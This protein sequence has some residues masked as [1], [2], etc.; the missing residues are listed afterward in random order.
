MS[1]LEPPDRST[2]ETD[3][4]ETRVGETSSSNG[5]SSGSSGT[6]VGESGVAIELSAD[7]TQDEAAAV[8]AAIGAHLTNREQAA[9]V[10][11]AKSDSTTYVDEWRFASKLRSLGKRR[12]TGDVEAGDEWKA[13]G[14][15]FPR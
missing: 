3:A 1:Q 6:A 14:R 9:A 11:V 15:A 12:W 7:A 4:E 2:D 13:A 10:A 8:A 5:S